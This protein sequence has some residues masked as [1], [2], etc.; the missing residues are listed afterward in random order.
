[1]AHIMLGIRLVPWTEQ[2]RITSEALLSFCG[3]NFGR[4]KSLRYPM[5]IAPRVY[6]FATSRGS[7]LGLSL[8]KDGANLPSPPLL[9]QTWRRVDEI[10]LT[11]SDIS[12]LN[13]DASSAIE[14]LIARGYVVTQPSAKVVEFRPA[15]KARY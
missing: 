2:P 9:T 14:L 13:V 5:S 7:R 1:M 8:M 6:V 3:R 15:Q 10:R 12:R 11:V 4:R